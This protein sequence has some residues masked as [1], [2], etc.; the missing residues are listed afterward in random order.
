MKTLNKIWVILDILIVIPLVTVVLAMPD[1]SAR[2]LRQGLEA[3][4]PHL[5]TLASTQRLMMAGIAV[6]VDLLLLLILYLELRRPSATHARVKRV[7][8]GVA[9]IAFDA[10]K[11]RLLYQ[12]GQVPGVIKV[13]SHVT[14]P[15]GKVKVRVDV[16]TTPHVVV[17]EKAAEIVAAIR[18]AIE[19]DMGLWLW[20]RPEVRIRHAAYRDVGPT[21]PPTRDAAPAPPPPHEAA[22]PP[23]SSPD[24]TAILPG[25]ADE[26][27]PPPGLDA[28]PTKP[29]KS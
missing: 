6:G 9:E 22:Q 21:P 5:A 19:H 2:L 8:G 10:I 20:G 29:A 4:T 23:S 11:Q 26:A 12:V 25:M 18:Q 28:P 1:A 13:A 7:D 14:A 15:R 27:P 17:P 16:E 24:S 3:L